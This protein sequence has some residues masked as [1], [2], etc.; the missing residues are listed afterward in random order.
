[1]KFLNKIFN[2][3]IAVIIIG[4]AAFFFYNRA[5]N[6]LTNK[7]EGKIEEASKNVDDV[8]NKYLAQTTEIMEKEKFEKDKALYRA[9]TQPIKINP[10]QIGPRPED[11]PIEQQI[12]KDIPPVTPSEVIN[13]Q[14]FDQEAKAKQDE[15]DR[16]EY[17]RQFIENAR[18]GGYEIELS[19]DNK[20]LKSTPIRKP[21]Q[22]EDSVDS[23]ESD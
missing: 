20:V 7:S 8:V 19:E 13:A 10:S 12:A 14:I 18:Q 22:D 1:M 6:N 17:R 5:Q 21:S 9:M 15:A 4:Y 2:Y 11:I 16:K 23:H 3:V